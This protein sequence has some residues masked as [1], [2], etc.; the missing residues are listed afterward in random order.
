MLAQAYDALLQSQEQP[1]MS[2]SGGMSPLVQLRR[3]QIVSALQGALALNP[4]LFLARSELARQYYMH[5]HYYDLADDLLQ[6]NLD[7]QRDRGPRAGESEE[8]FEARLDQ[9]QQQQLENLE[10]QWNLHKN[11]DL[12]DNLVSGQN[13]PVL[14]KVQLALRHGLARRALE[15]LHDADEDKLGR[16]GNLARFN[17]LITT[18]NLLDAKTPLEGR[19]PGQ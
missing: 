3:I 15:A 1:W 14:Q 17:L 18:G 4:D 11:Q 2:G 6:D 16:A 5:L 9:Q 8:E 12:Y 10:K 7:R 19:A 13:P